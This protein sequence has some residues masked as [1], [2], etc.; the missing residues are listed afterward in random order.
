MTTSPSS[1]GICRCYFRRNYFVHRWKEH[2]H[3]PEGTPGSQADR[4]AFFAGAGGRPDA[5]D[6]WLE[7][8]SEVARRRAFQPSLARLRQEV[9]RRHD[10]LHPHL[11]A[12]RRDY[13]DDRFL[14]AVQQAKDGK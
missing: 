7:V 9:A 14:E 3:L 4:E 5:E 10:R 1:F 8:Q 11:Y 12:L 13:L 6:A 2:L